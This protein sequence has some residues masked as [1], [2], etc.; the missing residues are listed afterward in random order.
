MTHKKEFLIASYWISIMS[1]I[2]LQANYVEHG[3]LSM[4]S[5]LKSLMCTIILCVALLISV[6]CFGI[7]CYL[8]GAA[9]ILTAVVIIYL[10]LRYIK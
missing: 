8:E 9:F 10:L 4:K 2:I 5:F 6:L 1:A 3:V 7:G